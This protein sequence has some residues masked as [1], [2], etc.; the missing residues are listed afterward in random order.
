MQMAYVTTLT[1][2]G[3]LFKCSA[4]IE[5]LCCALSAL[6]ILSVC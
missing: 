4:V 1:E 3:N 6:K 5:F 2:N